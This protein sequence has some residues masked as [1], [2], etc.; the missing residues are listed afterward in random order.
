[1]I[2]MKFFVRTLGM[3]LV[4]S[5][6]LTP[7]LA[8]A[9]TP[10]GGKI[11]LWANANLT[12][13]TSKVVVVGAV[14]DYGVGTSI[15]KDGKVDPNGAYERIVLKNGSFEAD[16]SVLNQNASSAPPALDNPSTCSFAFSFASAWASSLARLKSALALCAAAVFFAVSFAS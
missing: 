1:M 2:P 14:A 13:A 8:G 3:V 9:S 5:A 6:I 12:G 16:A 15:D 4:A 11:S 10:S 7:A